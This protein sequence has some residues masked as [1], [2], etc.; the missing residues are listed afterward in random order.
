MGQPSETRDI[1]AERLLRLERRIGD[2][3]DQIGATANHVARATEQLDALV[4]LVGRLSHVVDVQGESLL[5]DEDELGEKIKEVES[6]VGDLTQNVR[7]IVSRLDSLATTA[8]NAPAPAAGNA[9]R[10]DSTGSDEPRKNPKKK[11]G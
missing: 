8:M 9:A 5:G 10:P 6:R 11:P 2:L 1:L 7:T 3:G 4:G